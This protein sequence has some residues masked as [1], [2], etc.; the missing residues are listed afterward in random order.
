MTSAAAAS[1]P[2]SAPPSGKTQGEALKEYFDALVV[3]ASTAQ[4]VLAELIESLS[5]LT[6]TNAKLVQSIAQLTKANQSL[7]A[8]TSKAS[9][10]TRSERRNIRPKNFCINCKWK[11]E[12]TPDNCS[13]LEKN[14]ARRPKNWV[15]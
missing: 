13:E 8:Q 5:K 1:A 14:K 11:V 2:P 4:N 12:H 7:S 10:G 15:S 3:A 6:K 9:G